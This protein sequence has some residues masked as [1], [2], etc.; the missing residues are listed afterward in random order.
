MYKEVLPD[1]CPPSTATEMECVV[2]R[3][4]MK[5]EISKDEFIPYAISKKDNPRYNNLCA[6][7]AVSFYD[8]YDNAIVAYKEAVKRE[9]ELA[10]CTFI[11]ALKLKKEYGRGEQKKKSGHINIWLYNSWNF[12]NFDVISIKEINVQ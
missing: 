8:S 4:F 10:M 6:A 3:L 12:R 5:N 2:F 9:S 11:A 1:N 7:Y